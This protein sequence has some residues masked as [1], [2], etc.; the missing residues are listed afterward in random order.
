MTN[1]LMVFS[2]DSIRI[3]SIVLLWYVIIGVDK[4]IKIFIGI[5]FNSDLSKEG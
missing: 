4:Q 2:W 3:Q 1:F 5:V